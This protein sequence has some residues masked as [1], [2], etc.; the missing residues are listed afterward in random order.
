MT[1]L[2]SRFPPVVT[3]LVTR[4]A[5]RRLP[6]LDRGRLLDRLPPPEYRPDAD[7]DQLFGQ[8]SL[9]GVLLR[10]AGVDQESE[11]AICRGVAERLLG[12]VPDPGELQL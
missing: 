9:G 3:G 1:A 8:T 7:E 5:L 6:R 4:L 12:R 11:Y 2:V 10:I